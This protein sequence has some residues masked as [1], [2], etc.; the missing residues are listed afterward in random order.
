MQ[1]AHSSA[2]AVGAAGR[3]G[4]LGAYLTVLA[5]GSGARVFGLASQ[6]VVL[7]ILSRMLSKDGFG[8]LMTAFGF[9]RV[10]A[11]AL[12][13]GSSLVL[14]YHVSR[15]P[16]DR[17]AEVRLHRYSAVLSAAI[18]AV[19]A[20][21]GFML[22][23][24]IAHA[25]DKP[26]LAVWFRELAPFAIFSTLLTTSTGAL[27]GRSRISES[28]ALAEVA[29]N[30]VRIV[31]LP[32]IAWFHLPDGYV[33]HAMTLSV[34]IPWLW[35][36]R[37]LWDRS[38]RG[39]Q[40]WTAWD[41]SY[42]GKFVA[43]TLF[44]NQLGAV[45]ILVAGV[46]FP[47]EIVADYALA[48]RIAALYSF[49]Q[50]ALLKRFAPRAARLIDAK[51]F[52][53]LRQEFAVCRK[54]I[55]GCGALTIAGILCVA[56]FLLP[57]FGNYAGAWPFMIWLAIPTFIQSFY[58]TSDRTLIIAGQANVPLAATAASFAVLIVAPFASASL[59]GPTAIP[60]AM[61]AS[62]LL[63]NP[64][65]AAR[66]QRIFAI[67]TIHPRDILM[68]GG[69]IVALASYAL[70]GAAA[71]GVASVAVL[72]AIALYCCVSTMRRTGPEPRRAD[73]DSAET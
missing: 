56:P 29:P 30:A 58:D 36:G 71:A 62:K 72:G 32:A 47:S 5:V 16:D 39:W 35:S 27:E 73:C 25:L 18:A 14:L 15:R 4:R 12:G 20:L 54:L 65:V 53:A 52:A 34:L 51:D 37:R 63:F 55:I 2:S 70:T 26:G 22:A 11:A 60:A 69:G 57:V 1:I 49:F 10:G 50:L 13:I 17:A 42:C 59:L 40:P 46:L 23:D 21:A 66:V 33:A 9:Y 68:M 8:D 45:D 31:L 64:L 19:I 48:A 43:A 6:F 38:V 28:I 41:V 24:P 7:I 61:V 44:A 3:G 67:T